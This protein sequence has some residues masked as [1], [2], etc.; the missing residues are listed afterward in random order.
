M[1]HAVERGINL[2]KRN[3][4][5]VTRHDKLAVRWEAIVRIAA[6]DEW[7]KA[8]M[9]HGLDRHHGRPADSW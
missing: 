4:G 6:I 7:L 5:M 2:L 1:R 9:K 3:R 8:F